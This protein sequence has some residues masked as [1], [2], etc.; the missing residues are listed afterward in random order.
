MRKVGRLISWV[1][2]GAI[3]VAS[4][5]VLG[6]VAHVSLDVVMRYVFGLPL[7]STIL[8]VSVYY[9][10]AIAFLPLGLVEET[11][12]H[13]AVELL[14]E[15][16]PDKFQTVLLFIATVLTAVVTAAVAVRTGQDALVMHNAGAFSIEPS[17][18]I[19][20]W[21]SYFFLPIGLGLMSIVASWKAIAIVTGKNSG[22]RAL[23]V[24][25][26]YLAGE[27]KL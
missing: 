13:I 21:P 22:L 9:M 4:V 10:V 11:D 2:S 5:L 16:F 8:F 20:T 18:K 27:P 14:V 23:I 12:S 15:R 6:L 25:D 7:N 24:E 26:P 19:I 1:T 3:A 17:G